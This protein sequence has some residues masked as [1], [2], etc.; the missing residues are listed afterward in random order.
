MWGGRE[1]VQT[2]RPIKKDS[3]GGKTGSCYRICQ[4]ITCAS[5]VGNQFHPTLK[6]ANE[7]QGQAKQG[8]S[9]QKR[10]ER[11]YN[12]SQQ[13]EATILIVYMKSRQDA[14]QEIQTI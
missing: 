10:R 1:A 13:V 11:Q 4:M 5:T 8:P 6:C 7:E 2:Q 12:K 3:S 14:E 9:A